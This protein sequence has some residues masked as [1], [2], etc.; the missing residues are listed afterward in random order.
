ME[1]ATLKDLKQAMKDIPDNVLEK[2]GAGIDEGEFVELLCWDDSDPHSEYATNTNSYPILEDISK[3]IRN[4]S[5]VQDQLTIHEEYETDEPISSE[6][7]IEIKP[8]M[9]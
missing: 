8:K 1:I 2:F 9:E 7:K 4:I 5:Q 3:W 6:D